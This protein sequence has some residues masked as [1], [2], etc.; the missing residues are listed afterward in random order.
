MNNKKRGTEFE[1]DFC[2]LL[3]SCGH[4]AHFMSPSAIGSQPCDVVSAKNGNAY[5]F[6]CKTCEDKIFRIGRLEDNQICAFEKFM[7]AG[8]PRSYIAIKH[9]GKVYILPYKLLKEKQKVELTD[10]FLFNKQI[11]S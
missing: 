5:L 2:E 9:D 6:D 8:N 10:E 7:R 1:R 11:D 4:W 3:N